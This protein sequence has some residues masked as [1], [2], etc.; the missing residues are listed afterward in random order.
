MMQTGYKINIKL[1]FM[2]FI[3]LITSN[4]T[5]AGKID[6]A[7]IRKTKDKA[8]I[9]YVRSLHLKG[10]EALDFWKM[11]PLNRANQQINKIFRKEAFA[12]YLNKYPRSKGKVP[13]FKV[14]SGTKAKGPM[15]GQT[16]K[17]PFSDYYVLKKGTIG[18]PNR[19]Y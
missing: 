14:G 12:I 16:L 1:L 10:Q 18:D 15:N 11:L 9:E 8:F 17:L 4:T 13:E 7:K 2:V 6:W 19:I 3:I 5:I